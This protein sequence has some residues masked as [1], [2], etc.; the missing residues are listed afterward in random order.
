LTS[1]ELLAGIATFA[2]EASIGVT[3]SRPAVSVTSGFVPF[4]PNVE[5]LPLLALPTA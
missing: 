1:A 4:G 2:V 3:T 5:A